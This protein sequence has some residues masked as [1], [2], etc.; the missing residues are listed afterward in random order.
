MNKFMVVALFAVTLAQSAHAA[1]SVSDDCFGSL[2]VSIPGQSGSSF[3]FWDGAA[4]T[5]NDPSVPFSPTSCHFVTSA[6]GNQT[7]VLKGVGI[8]NGTDSPIV[9]SA[10]S[11]GPI[12]PA[13]TCWNFQAPNSQTLNWQLVIEV[14]GSWTLT[15]N[16]KK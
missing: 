12:P 10:F 14:D 2:V 3:M 8:W 16:F 11:G 5:P 7:Q 9:Y 15:C 6:S 1:A 4:K 13:Q